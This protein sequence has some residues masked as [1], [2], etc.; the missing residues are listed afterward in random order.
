M[1]NS[2]LTYTNSNIGI[3]ISFPPSWSQ[4]EIGNGNNIIFRPPQRDI[5]DEIYFNII[6]ILG[7]NMSI[8]VNSNINTSKNNTCEFNLVR[9]EPI[10][11]NGMEGYITSIKRRE[12]ATDHVI[13]SDIILIP[14]G[15]S[16][17]ELAYL[18]TD[19]SYYKYSQII[20]NML[21]SF[22]INNRIGN[23]SHPNYGDSSI[24]SDPGMREIV[25]REINEAEYNFATSDW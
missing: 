19:S 2:L 12:N 21:S 23:T 7:G 24:M 14:N 20:N 18:A 4:S 15:Y 8:L 11:L 9:N 22:R 1:D 6:Y 16:I 3:S 17:Y 13:I 25:K 10:I 5:S